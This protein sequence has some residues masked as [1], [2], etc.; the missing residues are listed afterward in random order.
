M[1]DRQLNTKFRSYVFG[2]GNIYFS[3]VGIDDFLREIK[4]KTGADFAE[5]FCRR[6]VFVKNQRNFFF[7]DTLTEINY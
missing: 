3:V 2:A 4:P 7:R 5:F 6:I 1:L